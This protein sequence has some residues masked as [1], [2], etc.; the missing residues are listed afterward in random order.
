MIERTIFECEH[1]NKKRLI[2]KYGMKKHEE[3]CFYNPIRKACITCNN[4]INEP[5]HQLEDGTTEAIAGEREC[6]VN[7]NIEKELRHNCPLWIEKEEI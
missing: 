6:E 5:I 7:Y 1:C 2:S 4:F 3:K